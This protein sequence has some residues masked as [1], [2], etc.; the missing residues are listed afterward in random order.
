MNMATSYSFI[1]VVAVIIATINR[2]T[3]AKQTAASISAV[4]V[5]RREE[6]DLHKYSAILAAIKPVRKQ[7]NDEIKKA[8]SPID[9]YLHKVKGMKK[10]TSF[11]F[12]ET[13]SDFSLI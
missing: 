6:V 13:M 7:L 12:F 5:F 10:R 3:A 4:C 8:L 2:H 1:T 9:Y 11:V